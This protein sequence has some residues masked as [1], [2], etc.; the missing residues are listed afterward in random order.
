[1]LSLRSWWEGIQQCIVLAVLV[2][3]VDAVFY[4][5]TIITVRTQMELDDILTCM[6]VDG[7]YGQA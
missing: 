4:P 1:M 2:L 5:Q 3:L 6:G 7:Y